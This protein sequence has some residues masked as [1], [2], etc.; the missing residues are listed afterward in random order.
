M[1]DKPDTP[2]EPPDQ[3]A[4]DLAELGAQIRGEALPTIV[5]GKDSVSPK[6]GEAP[7][8]KETPEGEKPVDSQEKS[9]PEGEGGKK[10][11]EG[12]EGGGQEDPLKDLAGNKDALKVLLEHPDLGPLLNS[13]NDRSAVAQVT[14]ALERE[15]PNIEANAKELEATRL[16]DAHFS[17][18]TQ[19][20]VSE[21]ITGDEKAAAA[22]AR[23]QQR[24]EA[25]EAPNAQAI[26]QASQVYSYAVRVA[27]VSSMLEDSELTAEV[28]ETLKPE[29]FTHLKAEGIREWEK[30]VFQA[31][32]DHTAADLT[33]EQLEEKFEA[34]KEEHLAEIDGERP[35]VVS[36]RKDGPSP[37]LIK[38]D[39]GTLLEG[40][41]S[42]ISKKGS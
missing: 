42:K 28:K 15:R 20:Q 12:E 16:E 1:A 2:A 33:K 22:Y 9:Q 11:G 7:G 39:S 13:W 6:G 5:E 26:A 25:G 31:I 41:L 36:G 32:V 3:E 21:E 18:M 8:E 37:D 17:E 29:H 30:A 40:A 24:K 23:Y 38:T 27:S 35:A 19:E 34:Y 14:S 10:P 4:K